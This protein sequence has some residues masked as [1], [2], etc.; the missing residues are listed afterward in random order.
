M[1]PTTMVLP[2]CSIASDDG[3]RRRHDL[4]A[5]ARVIELVAQTMAMAWRASMKD[6]AYHAL[7]ARDGLLRR[8]PPP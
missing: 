5:L 7:T 3:K 4:K 8:I 2:G 6:N 1:M